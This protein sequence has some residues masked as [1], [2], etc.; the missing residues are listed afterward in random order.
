M[1]Q[2][3]T[4]KMRIA[5]DKNELAQALDTVLKAVPTGKVTVQILEGV[6]L[7]AGSGKLCITCNNLESAIRLEIDCEVI[8]DGSVVV[9]SK[10]FNEIVKKM[11]NE[12]LDI[13]T[14]EKEMSIEAGKTI[15]KLPL[16]KA[17]FPEMQTVIEKGRLV[18]DKITFSEL[19]SKVAF[20][21][22][23]GEE[24]PVYT[25]IKIDVNAGEINV[26]ATDTYTLALQRKKIDAPDISVLLNG[27]SLEGI[28]KVITGE[29]TVKISIGENIVVLNSDNIQ[30]SAR[31]VE[32]NFLDYNRWLSTKH[33][34]QVQID[35]RIL[36]QS[37]ERAIL[38]LETG[39]KGSVV[40]ALKVSSTTDGLSLKN[41][42]QKGSFDEKI[43][44]GIKGS[45]FMIGVDPRRVIDC[46]KHI[47]AKEVVLNFS[48]EKTPLF[49]TP[50]D[51]DD[52]VYI[53]PLVR[54]R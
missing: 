21:V 30:A 27:K 33:E 8:Q 28:S 41:S 37:L 47:D 25:A 11:P 40:N 18:L 23:V 26:V 39:A 42:G 16:F 22:Y 15:M 10:L 36:M 46:L 45:D 35:K 38:V 29:G 6:L 19:V 20:A 24:K 34:T 7:T 49:I 31:T 5:I 3:G 13:V 51:G 48:G 32:G 52:F 44:G 12:E 14:N 1:K 43:P 2:G 4:L 54:T 50:V 9:N 17:E 53:I